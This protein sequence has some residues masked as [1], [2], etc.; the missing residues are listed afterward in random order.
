MVLPNIWS[1]TIAI[2]IITAFLSNCVLLTWY[3]WCRCN[4]VYFPSWQQRSSVVECS[5]KLKCRKL[6][7]TAVWITIL[8]QL[9]K[10]VNQI[11]VNSPG[12][13]LVFLCLKSIAA[14][15]HSL[16]NRSTNS[17]QWIVYSGQ[18]RCPLCGLI[19]IICRRQTPQSSIVN[20]QFLIWT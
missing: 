17:W 8:S 18:F 12:I 11:F 3:A 6:H 20:C 2:W 10:N 13:R 5:Y 14:I 15:F 9:H 19:K 1:L 7:T 16:K 4:F